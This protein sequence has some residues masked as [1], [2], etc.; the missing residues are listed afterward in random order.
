VCPSSWVA[1][2]TDRFLMIGRPFSCG[3]GPFV[4]SAFYKLI[5][6]IL[7]FSMIGNS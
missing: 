6:L 4:L 3:S 5:Q 2:W 1:D 7:H